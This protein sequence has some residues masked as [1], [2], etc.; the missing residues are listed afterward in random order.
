M[1]RL[2]CQWCCDGRADNPHAPSAPRWHPVHWR[3][4]GAPTFRQRSWVTACLLQL[5]VC[6]NMMW[7]DI[8]RSRG[9]EAWLYI[10]TENRDED[11]DTGA[12][13]VASI[14][15]QQPWVWANLTS[16]PMASKRSALCAATCPPIPRLQS[17]SLTGLQSLSLST[18]RPVVWGQED[19]GAPACGHLQSFHIW[20]PR[21]EVC[22]FFPIS[23]LLEVIRT[24][25]CEELSLCI[26]LD[27]S[28]GRMAADAR[29]RCLCVLIGWGD[30][31][32]S[33]RRVGGLFPTLR[34]L[35]SRGR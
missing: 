28:R 21:W 30:S 2:C 9:D 13:L 33:Y 18:S 25:K 29:G 3:Q 17:D 19:R 11:R 14:F 10:V 34:A 24:L 1:V 16:P 15:K 4:K 31:W 26:K 35:G 12:V 8:V 32:G 7:K 27:T 6:S 22:S 23:E 20:P 5:R